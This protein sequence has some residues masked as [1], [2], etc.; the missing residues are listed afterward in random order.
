MQ[1]SPRHS[2]HLILLDR[3]I[4]VIALGALLSS[5]WKG[6]TSRL[7]FRVGLA[8]YSGAAG[9]VLVVGIVVSAYFVQY[10]SLKKIQASLEALPWSSSQE[11]HSTQFPRLSEAVLRFT[12]DRNNCS[13]G[14]LLAVLE[15][16]GQKMSRPL[17]LSSSRSRWIYFTVFDPAIAKVSVEITP[18]ECVTERAWGPIGDGAI[19]P[20]QFLDPE[21]ALEKH[22]IMRHLYNL[23][24][25]LL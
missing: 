24:S 23:V 11:V 17:D 14:K 3:V 22:T 18:R 6:A 16:E 8:L 13:D 4:W 7:N 5:L 1:F 2:L 21:T 20:L 15:I 12:I 25:S 19:P 10:A 9:L